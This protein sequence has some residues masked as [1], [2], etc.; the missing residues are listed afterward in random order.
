MNIIETALNSILDASGQSQMNALNTRSISPTAIHSVEEFPDHHRLMKGFIFRLGFAIL[1]F[2]AFI[3]RAGAQQV[4][5][6]HG[7]PSALEQKML[8]LINRARMNPT[9]EGV[10][11]DAVNTAYSRDAR[12]RKPSFFSN[13]R[14]EFTAYPAVPPL[15]FNHKL[16]Q[17][18]RAHSQDML[19]RN[20]FAHVNPS[21]QDPTARGAAVGYDKGV[22]ENISGAGATSG[23][24]VLQSHFGFMVDYDNI[25]TSH[26]L[27]PSGAKKIG[28]NYTATSNWSLWWCFTPNRAW[29]KVRLST[30]D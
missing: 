1:A 8:E 4:Q 30:R 27:G 10:L 20:F 5:F 14:G 6:S 19:T 12:A 13:L 28:R 15:A 25:D 29:A 18:S 21:G 23:D 9:Q 2:V 11:L 22:G 3:A 24:E 7:E 17:S 26:P 16:I